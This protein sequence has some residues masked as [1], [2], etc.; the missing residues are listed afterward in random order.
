MVFKKT[1][2]LFLV[3]IALA[4]YY[5]LFERGFKGGKREAEQLEKTPELK[6]V[7]N[8]PREDISDI[9]ISRGSS[10]H[11]HYQ[12]NSR[13]W[14]MVEPQVIQGDAAALDA[15]LDDIE[16]ISDIET[17]NEN[18]L[19]LTEFGL[20]NPSLTIAVKTRGHIPSK[21]LFIGNDH[22]THT[23]LYAKTSDSPRVFMVGS[24]V[25]W[26]IDKEFDNIEHKR[27]PFFK[28]GG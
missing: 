23:A 8:L 1:F 17:V 15:F 27:G 12:K 6:R 10:E 26:I 4:G 5:Y 11:I 18:P 3:L 16:N 9:R 14:Q 21:N 28:T 7:F 24:L 20:D 19:S 2:F 13:G 25:R 22:P